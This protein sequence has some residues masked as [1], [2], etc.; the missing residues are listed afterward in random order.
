MN[1]YLLQLGREL[2]LKK[3]KI[4]LECHF[5]FYE[6]PHWL[7]ICINRHEWCSTNMSESSDDKNRRSLLSGAFNFTS[8][9]EA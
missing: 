6:Y 2:V 7:T 1:D 5:Y 8:F 3:L 4:Q 9:D